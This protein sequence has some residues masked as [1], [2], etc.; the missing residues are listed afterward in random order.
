MDYGKNLKYFN[1]TDKLFYI[2]LPILIVGAILVVCELLWFF[3]MPYQML[4][5]LAIAILGA[6]L[7]F[8]PRSLRANE[9]DIDAIVSAMTD[10]YAKEVTENLGLEK[11][12]LR[13]IPPTVIGNYIYDEKDILMRRGKDD[14]K[15]RTSKYRAAAVI[16]TKNG[17][18]ISQ[19]TFSLIDETVTETLYEF[20]FADI[21]SLSVVDNEIRHKDGTKI[22]DSRLILT[23]NGKEVLNLPTVHV[24]AVDRLC[25]D[26]NRMIASAKS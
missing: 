3:F 10:G 7:A 9:K 19:K 20:L 8:I 18:V 17:M 26:I 2:G 16:C 15:C 25:E 12:I 24:I 22:K 5:G 21:D 13:M 11:Q 23:E 4:I 6:A 14:R 1:S